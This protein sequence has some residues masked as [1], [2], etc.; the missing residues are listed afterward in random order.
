LRAK[1]CAWAARWRRSVTGRIGS[2]KS[3]L[4]RTLLGLLTRDEGEIYWNGRAV[5]DPASFFVPP[6][7]AYRT[8]AAG[9]GR[10]DVRP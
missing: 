1:T 5:A 9:R 2:G 7:C 6:R 4:L 10:E 3:C 8:G